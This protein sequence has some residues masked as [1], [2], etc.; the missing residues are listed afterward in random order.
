VLTTIDWRIAAAAAFAGLT[1]RVDSFG[2]PCPR[3]EGVT[4]DA[5]IG[6]R[7]PRDGSSGP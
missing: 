1:E 3:L 5:R 7:S 2:A 6:R 4:L